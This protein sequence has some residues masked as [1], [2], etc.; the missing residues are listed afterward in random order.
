MYNFV[1]SLNL[2]NKQH[3]STPKSGHRYCP[4]KLAP[5]TVFNGSTITEPPHHIQ[6]P[7][8][9]DEEKVRLE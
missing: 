4:S 8:I 5:D 9:Y 6:L 1:Q 2:G 7:E 3:L